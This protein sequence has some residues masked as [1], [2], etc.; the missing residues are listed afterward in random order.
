MTQLISFL[1]YISSQAVIGIAVLIANDPCTA[2]DHDT[3]AGR[4]ATVDDT[5]S[6]DRTVKL[7]VHGTNE[8]N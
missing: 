7:N 6:A 8:W 2:S 5:G 1:F 3:A 4:S